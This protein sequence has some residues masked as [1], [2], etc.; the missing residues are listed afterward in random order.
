[1]NYLTFAKM[2]HIKNKTESGLR[3]VNAAVGAFQVNT[4]ERL[5]G[6]GART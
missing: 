6:A 5:V 3:T 1:M 2:F 4:D